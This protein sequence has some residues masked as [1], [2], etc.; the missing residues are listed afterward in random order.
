MAVKNLD[1]KLREQWIDVLLKM[2]TDAGEDAM[3]YKSN[4]ICIPVVDAE[5][6]EKWVQFVVKVP[7]GTRDGDEFDGYS[8]KEEYE[9]KLKE[10]EEKAKADAEKKARKI[11]QDK[12]NRQ[13]RKERKERG[14]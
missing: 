9:L 12:Q 7:K 6:N 5:G 8:M 11:E 14:E 10:K 3:R 4:E 13:A 2:L 1:G